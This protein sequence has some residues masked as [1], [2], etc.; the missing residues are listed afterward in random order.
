ME[1]KHTAVADTLQPERITDRGEHPTTVDRLIHEMD[2]DPDSWQPV[3]IDFDG[4]PF[5]TRYYVIDDETS[6]RDMDGQLLWV[7]DFYNQD[8]P[9]AWV[10]LLYGLNLGADGISEEELRSYEERYKSGI[11]TVRQSSLEERVR[12]QEAFRDRVL[13]DEA[14]KT[15]DPY[16]PTKSILENREK[17]PAPQDIND[18]WLIR[19]LG[20]WP[21]MADHFAPASREW[22]HRRHDLNTDHNGVTLLTPRELNY[23]ID[24]AALHTLEDRR[25]FRVQ[26][27]ERST[28]Y[29]L[30]DGE[31][32]DGYKP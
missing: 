21:I 17:F 4:D 22:R 7:T 28:K 25:L 31:P 12:I 2:V 20:S 13:V 24:D 23:M 9:T 19:L 1:M 11:V 10:G 27:P 32:D 16:S 15:A 6:Q 29:L 14:T 8:I 30:L 26:D 5:G 3:G 18:L